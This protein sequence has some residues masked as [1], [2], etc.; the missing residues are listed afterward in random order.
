MPVIILVI[1]LVMTQVMRI[2][3][4]LS[5]QVIQIIPQI[6]PIIPQIIQIVIPII[7]QIAIQPDIYNIKH[8][9]NQMLIIID[10]HTPVIVSS[11]GINFITRN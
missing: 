3:L 8:I 10:H 2:I 9:I 1:I 11:M 6:I 7:P 5:A 4:D